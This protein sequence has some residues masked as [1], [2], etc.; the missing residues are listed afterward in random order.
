MP[1][2][3]DLRRYALAVTVGKGGKDEVDA[4]ESG[5]FIFPHLQPWIRKRQMRMYRFKH[6][7]GLAVAEQ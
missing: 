7:P 6:L 2:R 5:S 3:D 4:I 1:S